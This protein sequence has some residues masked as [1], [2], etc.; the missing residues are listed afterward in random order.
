MPKQ[1]Y[2]HTL[3]EPDK[4]RA[5]YV[6]ADRIPFFF[7]CCKCNAKEP[8]IHGFLSDSEKPDFFSI[9][10]IPTEDPPTC[11]LALYCRDCWIEM[12]KKYLKKEDTN[13]TNGEQHARD[14]AV[15]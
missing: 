13:G 15:C 10:A 5:G 1:I 3:L 9:M 6:G 14:Q 11:R 2:M 8:I 4:W 7:D 12:L